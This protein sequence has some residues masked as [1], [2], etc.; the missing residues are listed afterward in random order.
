MGRSRKEY[1]GLD[2]VHFKKD[3]VWK[4][5][6]RH[7]RRFLKKDALPPETY[8]K[9]HLQKLKQQGKLLC[10]ALEIPIELQS[11]VKTPL[12]ILMMVSS[13]RITRKK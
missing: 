11:D 8:Q 2:H 4:P 10:D 7:F 3:A 13:H 1:A 9:V 6:I 12:A 5:L